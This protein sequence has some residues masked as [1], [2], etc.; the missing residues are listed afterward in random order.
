MSSDV[1]LQLIQIK[2]ETHVLVEVFGG[3]FLLQRGQDDKWRSGAFIAST[4]TENSVK[5]AIKA[6]H[7][8][9]GI[10]APRKSDLQ[11]LTVF[12]ASSCC[13]SIFTYLMDLREEIVRPDPEKVKEI[14]I[15]KL[16]DVIEDMHN[17]KH[18]YD[19]LF[20]QIFNIFLTLEK[21]ITK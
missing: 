6:L 17:Y 15:A 19:P 3:R 2:Y 14:T 18:H 4:S 20:T 7:K 12:R 13:A 8:D 1:P 16:E 11:K 5:S 9:I 21:G 10:D